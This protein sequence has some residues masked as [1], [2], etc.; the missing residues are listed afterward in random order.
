MIMQCYYLITKDSLYEIELDNKDIQ[1]DNGGDDNSPNTTI[2]RTSKI[3]TGKKNTNFY[4]SK[5]YNMIIYILSILCLYLFL[6]IL[7]SN[8]NK[9]SKD[10]LIDTKIT[11]CTQSDKPSN[12]FKPIDNPIIED[13]PSNEFKP[14]DN[15]IIE[16]KPSNKFKPIDNPIIEDKLSNESAPIDNPNIKDKQTNEFEPI[17]NDI[18]EDKLIDYE[19]KEIVNKFCIDKMNNIKSTKQVDDIFGLNIFTH[20]SKEP[21]NITY[22]QIIE[23]YTDDDGNLLDDKI[24][25]KNQDETLDSIFKEFQ[26]NIKLLDKYFDDQ[27]FLFL[28]DQN[29]SKKLDKFQHQNNKNKFNNYDTGYV[30]LYYQLQHLLKNIYKKN[31]LNS[32]ISNIRNIIKILKHNLY[33]FSNI[34]IHDIISQIIL[35][36]INKID[37]NYKTQN[38]F[39]LDFIYY[40]SFM[41]HKLL[42]YESY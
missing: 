40:Q 7:S 10:I 12:E 37:S 20:K 19:T 26:N 1:L 25:T 17:Y 38:S 22:D 42:A 24:N 18:I 34:K 9:S 16:D 4:D 23:M 27:Y 30:L 41:L 15:P 28:N 29:K 13:K 3:I 21:D 33:I 31:D 39:W 11:K 6:D 35:K 32:Y 36:S 8:N 2:I 14:I 5:Y